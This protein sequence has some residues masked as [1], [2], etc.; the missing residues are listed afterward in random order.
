MGKDFSEERL[1]G[2]AFALEGDAR[3]FLIPWGFFPPFWVR[4][5]STLTPSY[6]Y[7]RISGAP[8]KPK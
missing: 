6:P 1:E 3:P 7:L 4:E 5:L 2:A 8:G